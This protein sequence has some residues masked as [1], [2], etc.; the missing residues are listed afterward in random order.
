MEEEKVPG[1]SSLT[2]KATATTKLATPKK[3]VAVKKLP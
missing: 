2:A 3:Q 1:E